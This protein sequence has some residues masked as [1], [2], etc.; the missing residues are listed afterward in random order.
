MTRAASLPPEPDSG[1]RPARRRQRM[2]ELGLAAFV[3][4]ALIVALVLY[5]SASGAGIRPLYTLP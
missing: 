5:L 4:V 2:I 3:I 1:R